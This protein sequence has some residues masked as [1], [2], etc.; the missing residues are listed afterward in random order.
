[1]DLWY[2]SND[3]FVAKNTQKTFLDV[4]TWTYERQI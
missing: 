1:M 2:A 4:M 3:F